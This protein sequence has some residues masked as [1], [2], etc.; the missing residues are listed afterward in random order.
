MCDRKSFLCQKHYFRC[1]L[2]SFDFNNVINN[3]RH[4]TIVECNLEMIIIQF[5]LLLCFRTVLLFCVLYRNKNIEK[6]NKKCIY[7]TFLICYNYNRILLQY[8][9]KYCN[10][11]L[12]YLN[13]GTKTTMPQK[14]YTLRKRS[15][16]Q[17]PKILLVQKL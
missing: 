13:R 1:K 17:V 2:R 7:C 10:K 15:K 6:Q 12:K 16:P 4:H 8:F 3:V 9:T 14:L 5:S 11:M